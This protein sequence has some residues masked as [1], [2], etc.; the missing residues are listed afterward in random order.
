MWKRFMRVVRSIFGGLIAK[1]ENPRAILEQNIRDMKD[2]IPEIN[3]GMV[4]ARVGIAL[5]EKEEADFKNEIETITV[6]IKACL[7]NNE[8]DIAAPMALRLN[9]VQGLLK[10]NLEQQDAAKKGYENMTVLKTRFM[11]EIEVKISEATQAIKEAEA[12][13]WKRGLAEVFSS[14]SI[15]DVSSTHKEMV[16]ILNTQAL[17]ADSRLQLAIEDSNSL[18]QFKMEERASLI[19]GKSSLEK[20]KLEQGLINNAITAASESL[21]P[22]MEK[23]IG[24]REKIR[25]I[26]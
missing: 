3:K 19:M 5:F 23:T 15:G 9:H 18:N 8:E 25:E 17:E 21:S 6:N 16:E 11:R 2:K 7:A 1:N 14:F 20:F 12:T 10:K 26:A 22:P 4:Q 24:P 13:E